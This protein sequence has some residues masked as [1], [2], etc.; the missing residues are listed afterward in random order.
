MDHEVIGLQ[1]AIHNI[2]GELIPA[3]AA[4]SARTPRSAEH[5]DDAERVPHAVAEV[6]LVP[7]VSSI[8]RGKSRERISHPHIR[9]AGG[10][11]DHVSVVQASQRVLYFDR[12]D[13]Q[14]RSDL[15]GHGRTSVLHEVPIDLETNVVVGRLLR[16]HQY[17][18]AP[19]VKRAGHL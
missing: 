2:D 1:M 3:V 4:T 6:T 16:V 11:D 5:G 13:V 19:G 18:L 12:S 15:G 14:S 10:K 8:R 7:D 9:S 17:N